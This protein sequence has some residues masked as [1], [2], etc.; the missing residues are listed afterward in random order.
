MIRHVIQPEEYDE[1]PEVS[2]AAFERGVW[3]V[4]GEAVSPDEGKA[5][6]RQAL[7][8]GRPKG[9]RKKV[10]PAVRFD[11]D[12]IEAFRATGAGWQ[13]RMNA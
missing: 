10:S 9:S 7:K 13:T 12:I 4:G 5:A 3:K 2:R 1:L 6:F 11:A 8:R